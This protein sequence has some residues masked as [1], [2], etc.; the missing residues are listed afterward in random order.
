M[1]TT[2]GGVRLGFLAACGVIVCLASPSA[3]DGPQTVLARVEVRGT[4]QALGLP[5]FADLLG[6][7]GRE[8]ALVVA[9]ASDIAARGVAARVLDDRADGALYLLALERRRGARAAAAARMPVLL[10]DGR[11]VVVR[12]APGR[13]EELAD[14][15]LDVAVVGARPI[16]Q[17][18]PALAPMQISFDQRVAEMMASVNQTDVWDEDGNISGENTVTIGGA[19][20]TI[21]T[22]NTNSGTPIQKA[23]Q[24][25]YEHL[26][27]LG[28]SVS[29][30]Q[31]DTATDPNVVGEK[32]GVVNPTEI[33]LV[34][35]HIDDMPSSGRAPGADD[36]GS[37]SVGVLLAARAMAAETFGRT[38]RFVLF[39]GEEQGLLGSAAY[40]ALVHGRGDNIVAVYNMDMIAY[41]GVGGPTLRLHTRTTGSA[42]YPADLA[43]AQLFS[44]VLSTYG[45]T[46]LLTPIV[47]PDAPCDSDHC[48]FWNAGYPAILAIEDDYDDFNPYYHSSSDLRAHTNLTYFTNYVK[49]SIG[50]AAH[51]AVPAAPTVPTGLDVDRNA[52]T[53]TVSNLNGILEPGETVMLT[54]SWLCGE[55]CTGTVWT[56]GQLTAFT[57]PAGFT[58]SLPDSFGVYGYGLYGNTVDCE[59]SW[60][61]CYLVQVSAGPRPATHVDATVTETLNIGTIKTWTLHIGSSFPDVPTTYWSYP[62]VE[63][64]LHSGI[65]AGCG[66]GNY[67]P[68]VSVD[69]WQ[70]AVFLAKAETGN[71]VPVSGTVPGM[72]DY[73]CVAGGH[74]VFGDVAPTDAGCRFIHYIAAAGITVGCGDGDY[75]PVSPVTRWQMAVFL[76]KADAGSG[77]PVSGTVPGMGDYD[78]VA[79]G[80]SVFADVAPEDGGCKHIHY[81]AAKGITVGCGNGNYCPATEVSRD[82]MAV[83]ITKAY[84][85]QLYG[86]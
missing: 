85:L 34:T 76:A 48:E 36:N 69:R 3:A 1:R 2:V 13:A 29:Y 65:T 57:G 26:Q 39:T 77:V 24:Y 33:V 12:A 5:V 63:A 8:Y 46:G 18:A 55:A 10:D 72:G 41:D 17:R 52:A 44:D 11:Q 70:M 27:A 31:W 75:C 25:A 14:L 15:G 45:M 66:G 54:P 30:Q 19:P 47:T 28:Y 9:P 81:I 79:G 16:E 67:C 61:N 80:Q 4:V 73:D 49:A 7:D 82:Q 21:L 74:S 43:I 62:H 86:P 38:V 20:Y 68:T 42:G 64:L 6:A 50:T 78:C 23:T 37:G 35:A 71:D 59:S 58:Y 22:R 53:G 60:H 56:T 84:G 51:L 83:F 40:A 32:L